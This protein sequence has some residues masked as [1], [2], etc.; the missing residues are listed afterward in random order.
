M[1]LQRCFPVPRIYS[2]KKMGVLFLKSIFRDRA[3]YFVEYANNF[4]EFIS[5]FALFMYKYFIIMTKLSA[6]P[7]RTYTSYNKYIFKMVIEVF[8]ENPEA[9]KKNVKQG[10]KK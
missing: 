8:I 3:K 6:P 1:I 4:I 5:E 10:K 7:P 9:K 2:L